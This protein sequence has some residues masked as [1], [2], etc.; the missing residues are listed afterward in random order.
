M[1]K[2]GQGA[3]PA[4]LHRRLAKRAIVI[5][6]PCMRQLRD[7]TF[8]QQGFHAVASTL[9]IIDEQGVI[10]DVNTAW[11]RF[12]EN[13][14]LT[15]PHHGIGANYLTI[16]EASSLPEAHRVAR[17]IR[18]VLRGEL[19]EFTHTYTCHAPDE[20]RW[21]QLRVTRFPNVNCAMIVHENISSCMLAE[22]HLRDQAEFTHALLESTP[23]GVHL[24]T[25]TGS[26]V[27]VNDA[28]VHQ[29]GLHDAGTAH[30][31]TWLQ[32]WPP[33]TQQPLAAALQT[34]R[35]GQPAHV[36]V[37]ASNAREAAAYLDVSVTPLRDAG[38]RPHQLLVTVHDLSDLHAAQAESM[39][40][41]D[42]T[43]R[44][45]LNLR[46]VF[47]T[48]DDAWRLTYVNPAAERLM[49]RPASDLL[50]ACIW[51][52]YPSLTGSDFCRQAQEALREQ[53]SVHFEMHEATGPVWLDVTIYPHPPGVAVLA[54]NVTVRKAEEH[55]QADRNRIL[56][57][58]VQGQPLPS[59][60]QAVSAMVESRLGG[61]SCAVM[62]RH[63]GRV[64][65]AAAS[66]PRELQRLLN[67]TA[68]SS[69]ICSAALTDARTVVIDDIA[70][71]PACAEWRSTL[72]LN[73]LRA[74]LSLP[75]LNGVNETL[76]ALVL[77][78][79]APGGFTQTAMQELEKARHLA[80]VAIE[81][82]RLN[83][84]LVRQ[85][86]HDALTGLANRKLFEECLRDAIETARRT[87]G[88]VAL[89]FIDVDDFK[90]VNDSLGHQHGDH[91][92]RE[93]ARRLQQCA[94]AGDTVARI[95]GD[96][97]TVIAAVD[98]E[99]QAARVAQRIVRAFNAPIFLHDR[100]MHVTASIGV[101][102]TPEGGTDAD[103]LHRNADLAMYHAKSTKT[104]F[105]VYRAEMNRR[106]Y[107]RFQ[108]ASRF[109]TALE[110]HE[111]ELHYQPQVQL[112]D[113]AVIGVEALLRWTHPQL[114]NVSPATFIPIAEET[115][116]IVPIG[117]WV[118]R[119]ACR[120]G[121]AWH[122]SGADFLRVAVNVS[123]LQFEREDFVDVVSACVRE[124]GFPPDRLELELT[125][126]VVMRNVE[127]SAWRMQQLRDLGVLI[128]VDDFGTGYSSLSYLPR[129]PINVLKI[130]RSF[131]TGL[132]RSSSTFPVVQAILSLARSL[133]LDTIA[134]GIETPE[135]LAVLRELGCSIG[136][137][138]LFAPPSAPCDT[139]LLS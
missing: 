74:S 73:G 60:L 121:K 44:L 109:R 14:G 68:E 96:E 70:T 72:L 138:N 107:E 116:L 69:V 99:L 21:Y 102:V 98:D 18:R 111:L 5:G 124:T 27:W 57:M 46:D 97:F 120:Q 41:S 66:L 117:T 58:T 4:R 135:E 7:G 82:H 127:E 24:L 17:G 136:Q 104:G 133:N 47:F 108:I 80:A 53:R 15:L 83:E 1:K 52:L 26:V 2:A 48:L 22:E 16:C 139:S 110:R 64:Q 45:L 119:E 112:H 131:V 137:G 13:N 20:R 91:V 76:G 59:I 29:L 43:M 101:A 84:Q 55:A 75:I 129:L 78:A 54:R 8:F 132:N 130:D 92:L 63:H 122:A 134:E 114:G 106:A 12:A 77:F 25:L 36:Q 95:S 90:S 42:E 28:A 126:R 9:A 32:L 79:P 65:V 37:H 3:L 38:G 62:L 10:L 86:H 6:G 85:A 19:A 113:R 33:P 118:L 94:H 100:E 39:R 11:K 115:G 51:D 40:R 35:T 30:A 67:G 87:G 31:R 128:S 23:V 50:G 105:A 81:H 93:F 89:L 88:H 123:A 56:E 61:L 71:H 34:A 49:Q 125:E 103:T